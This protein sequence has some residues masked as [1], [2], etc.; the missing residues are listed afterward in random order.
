MARIRTQEG[1]IQKATEIHNGKYDYLLVEYVKS[2]SKVKI[3]C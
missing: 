3:I 1:F 2:S